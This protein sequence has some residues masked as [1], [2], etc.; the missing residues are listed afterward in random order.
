MGSHGSKCDCNECI[1][2][3]PNS[4]SYIPATID[5]ITFSFKNGDH[6]LSKG[7]YYD[8]IKYNTSLN[9]IEPL[10]KFHAKFNGFIDNLLQFDDVK[11]SIYNSQKFGDLKSLDYPLKI[12]KEDISKYSIVE[13]FNEVSGGKKKMKYS[14][15]FK[16]YKKSKKSKKSKK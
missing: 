16:H 11:Q 3:L 12:S 8:L 1:K 7:Q 6:T 4:Q 2:T 5:L 10:I 13:S 15:K 9:P 14:K